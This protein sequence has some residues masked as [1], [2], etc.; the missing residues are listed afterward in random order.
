M[1]QDMRVFKISRMENVKI[2]D[3]V[4]ERDF[5]EKDEQR[6]SYDMSSF[7]RLVLKIDNSQAYRVLDEFS[8]SEVLKNDDG[9]FTV[10]LCYPED[11]WVYGFILSFGHYA[12]VLEPSHIR[13][14]ILERLKKSLEKYA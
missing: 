8:D 2:T 9:S 12:E 14:I 5:D 6:E 7:V 1:R 10:T 4:Y 11:E 13:A 3:A